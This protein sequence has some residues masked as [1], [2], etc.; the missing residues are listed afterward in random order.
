[1]AL[2]FEVLQSQSEVSQ[3]SP[4]SKLAFP[5]GT[6]T[7]PNLS[8][9]YSTIPP[10]NSWTALAT[11]SVTVLFWDLASNL[12]VL[13]LALVFHYGHHF[14]GCYGNIKIEVSFLTS[15]AKSLSPTMSAPA[16]MSCNAASPRSKTPTLTCSPVPDGRATVP[17]T[18]SSALRG[19]TPSRQTNSIVSSIF[20]VAYCLEIASDSF[21]AKLASRSNVCTALSYRFP[22]AIE[23]IPF[24][25]LSPYVILPHCFLH[26]VEVFKVKCF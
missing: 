16:T 17:R 6:W 22:F 12:V 25:T 13:V 23:H 3:E 18:I 9:R 14:W 2:L 8:V 5:I 21:G 7:F 19:S 11:L 4:P 20:A 24:R 10:L 26:L 15:S 1:M